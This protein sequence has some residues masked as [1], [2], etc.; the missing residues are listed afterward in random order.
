MIDVIAADLGVN[1]GVDLDT[2]HLGAGKQPPDM[3]VVD[4]IASDRAEHGAHTADQARL[5]AVGDV[6][7]AHDM[8][9]DV[10]L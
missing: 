2:G 8:M 4:N 3:D 10:V 6:I 9:S 1:R 5:F 7:V